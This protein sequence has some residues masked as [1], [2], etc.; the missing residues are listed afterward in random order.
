VSLL[1]PTSQRAQRAINITTIA[2]LAAA[3]IAII[4]LF[5]FAAGAADGSK[6]MENAFFF[7]VGSLIVG[8]AL[9][10]LKPRLGGLILLIPIIIFSYYAVIIFYNSWNS[11]VGYFY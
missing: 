10:F 2:V 9:S 1:H 4:V 3:N 6:Q 7:L 11:P 5:S 8:V